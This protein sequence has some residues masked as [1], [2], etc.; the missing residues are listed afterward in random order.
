MSAVTTEADS[1]VQVQV[2]L[3]DDDVQSPTDG[4]L[5]AEQVDAVEL[6][7][8]HTI[9][10]DQ[11]VALSAGQRFSVVE[12]I[13]GAQ[14]AYLP[15]EVAGHDSTDPDEAAGGFVLKK[16]QAAVANAGE[17]FYS[18]D[19]GATWL[20]ASTLTTDD[21]RDR[22]SLTM[23]G[24]DPEILGVGNAMIKAFTVDDESA[25]GTPKASG[26]ADESTKKAPGKFAS[27]V[28]TG[29]ASATA[30]TTLVLLALAAGGALY[31]VRRGKGSR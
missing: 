15:L 10:L 26:A 3:L 22:V 5:V 21:L 29:D 20:D 18:T 30:L 16:Q 27:L 19:G 23:F 12:S 11:P 28:K 9:E 6:S 25:A 13:N 17:S 24:G 1:T 31:T 7:G 2:Y 4:T 8:Y 14:G